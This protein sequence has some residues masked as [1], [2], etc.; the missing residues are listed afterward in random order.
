MKNELKIFLTALMFYTRFP[1]K[2]IEGWS[3]ELL[4]K[5]T[6]YF[7]LIGI[8][9]GGVGALFFYGAV[10]LFTI[11]LAVIL[12]MVATVFFTGAFHEDGFADFCDGFGGGYS[13]ERILE[14]MKDSRIGTYGSIGLLLILGI[15]FLALTQI[16]IAR[17]PFIIIAGHAVSRLFPVLLIYTSQ[18]ARLDASSKT[19]PI[20]KADSV[21]SLIFV[22][23]LGGTTLF[24]LSWLEAIIGIAV[25]MVVYLFFRKYIIR[26]LGGYT[27][28]V[29]GALQQLCEVFFYL[30]IVGIQN[31]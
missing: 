27:G 31:F 9:V 20:G 12:S 17:I 29:L 21:Y 28:D 26:K 15:K 14:I 22:L 6:R 18:Y 19:K 7:P 13:K 25:L 4:N 1:V 3:E 30:S 16:E 2:H 8:L 5:S 23:T 24:L 10:Q 11:S